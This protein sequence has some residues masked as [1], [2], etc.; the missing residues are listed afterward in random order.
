MKA[1]KTPPTRLLAIA[2]LLAALPAAAASDITALGTLKN[3][4]SG[5]AEAIAVNSDG[6]QVFGYA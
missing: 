3:D 2:A 5:L 6:T 4:N 1:I